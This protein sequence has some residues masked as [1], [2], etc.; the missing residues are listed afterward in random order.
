MIKLR[1]ELGEGLETPEGLKA[2]LQTAIELEHATIPPYLYAMYS[3][4]GDNFGI[5]GL[6]RSVVMEEMGHFALACNILNAIG[7]SPA[8]ESTG[9]VPSYPGPLPGSVEGHLTVPLAPFSIVLVENVFMVIEEPENPLVFPDRFAA[10]ME[11]PDLTIG[12]FYARISEALGSATFTANRNQVEGV[13]PG[14]IAVNTLEDARTAIGTIVEQGEGTPQ[15]P[16]DSGGDLAHY[17]RFEEIVRGRTLQETDGKF[18]FDGP[19]IT[20]DPTAV[21]P[22]VTNPK[23]ARYTGAAKAAND[24]FNGTYAKLLSQLHSGFNGT[25]DDVSAAIGTMFSLKG[26]A[27]TVMK[28]PLG[29]GSNANAGPTFEL[30]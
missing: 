9:F 28:T 24:T 1:S 2:A 23:G 11:G 25:P 12:Q 20:F 21:L 27:Q 14:V 18:A 16:E 3:L 22:L 8:I 5:A 6:I 4:T 13:L 26:D 10:E 19:A 7:G 29:D 30:V 15:T 17:Y